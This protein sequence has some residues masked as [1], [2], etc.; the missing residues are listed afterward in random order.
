MAETL[1]EHIKISLF[2]FIRTEINANTGNDI[3]YTF[4][5]YLLEKKKFH[6][7]KIGASSY[8]GQV[9]SKEFLD[10]LA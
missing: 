5:S 10:E 6:I 2:G 9:G 4:C 3:P 7:G 8:T 1:F